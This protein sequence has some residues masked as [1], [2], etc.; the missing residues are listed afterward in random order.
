[1]K[2]LRNVGLAMI[3]VSVGF[4]AH[5]RQNAQSASTPAHSVSM[6][7][8]TTKKDTTK[9]DTTKKDTSAFVTRTN[10]VA[11]YQ[12]TTKKDTTKKDTSKAFSNIAFYQ[13]TTKKDTA[14]K[15][16]SSL[17]NT[18]AVAFYQDTTKKDTTKKDTTKKDTTAMFSNTAM[19]SLRRSEPM[20]AIEPVSAAK[21][22]GET[23]AAKKEQPA[24]V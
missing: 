21:V 5:A 4:V 14:K 15:D 3:A 17:L 7:Q 19:N 13:D 1:M 10:A 20:V 8:D 9:K 11:F 16:T 12:D 6:Y 2:N 24:S 23:T 18:V 22:E